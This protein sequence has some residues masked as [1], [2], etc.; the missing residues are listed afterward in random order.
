[1]GVR[2][3]K[4]FTP[5]KQIVNCPAL[6]VGAGT[7]YLTTLCNSNLCSVHRDEYAQSNILSKNV[8]RVYDLTMVHPGVKHKLHTLN[9]HIAGELG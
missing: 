5:K 2:P 6:R 3:H 7:H 1:M 9:Q 8:D 4:C